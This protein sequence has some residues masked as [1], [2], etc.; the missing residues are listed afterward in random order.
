MSE[1]SK[2]KSELEAQRRE[3]INLQ[4]TV[5]SLRNRNKKL[6]AVLA[7]AAAPIY[8]KDADGRYLYV[9]KCFEELSHV[10]MTDLLGRDDNA[11]FPQA[12]A[13]MFI[14]QDQMVKNRGA[15][16]DFEETVQLPDGELHFITSKFPVFDENDTICAVGGFCTDIT[17]RKKMEQSLATSE[18]RF[19]LVFETSPDAISIATPDGVLLD[20][21]DS[22]LR[23]TGVPRD[24]VI[25]KSVADLGLWENTAQHL[26][27]I[28][29]LKTQGSVSDLETPCRSRDGTDKTVLLNA[30]II[31]L[32]GKRHV[33][34]I[35]RDITELKRAAREQELLQQQRQQVQKLESIGILAGGIA[36][37]F[38]NIL[39]AILGN[40]DLALI[41]CDRQHQQH[42]LSQSKQA[43]WRAQGLTQQLL[44]F[45]KGGDPI[46][47]T[48]SLEEI[49]RDT[50]EPVCRR[51]AGSASTAAPSRT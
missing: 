12:T 3:N 15:P 30:K 5:A 10:A 27:I 43:C 9:N 39:S 42:L 26:D 18:E 47:R 25:C 16:L 13:Q 38:N 49:V 48:A 45:A 24:E 46:K 37:D 11:V 33:L 7:H 32:Q 1:L 51:A 2:L 35:A 17:K 20:V 14:D 50:A 36:H 41:Q 40:I 44:T 34:T 31:Q 22:F 21:N 8:L 4:E 23:I 29:R 6:E 28:E 19:R